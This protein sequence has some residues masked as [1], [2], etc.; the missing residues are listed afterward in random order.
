MFFALTCATPQMQV[1]TTVGPVKMCE[2]N[3]YGLS[4]DSPEGYERICYNEE[5][6]LEWFGAYGATLKERFN[7]QK[8]GFFIL[9][10]DPDVQTVHINVFDE[11]N[12][13]YVI[14]RHTGTRVGNRVWI[15]TETIACDIN[16]K[17]IVP[18]CTMEG[19]AEWK[20]WNV[21]DDTSK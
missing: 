12:G 9:G 21:E 18:Y 17:Q 7:A 16:L 2:S 4:C 10:G 8:Q 3:N 1:E 13:I 20:V 6:C 15:K 14:G 11:P 19:W 5:D